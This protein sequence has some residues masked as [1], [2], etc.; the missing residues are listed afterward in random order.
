MNFQRLQRQ[1]CAVGHQTVAIP[2]GGQE[3]Q[4]ARDGQGRQAG[5]AVH[6]RRN[7]RHG[8]HQDEGDRWVIP[9]TGKRIRIRNYTHTYTL[10]KQC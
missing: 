3:Q 9:R 4:A 6:S 10:H 5:Q 7:L 2:S 1:D 8:P